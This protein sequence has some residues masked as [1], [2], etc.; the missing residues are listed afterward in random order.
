MYIYLRTP[1]IKT[2]NDVTIMIKDVISM[3]QVINDVIIYLII[4]IIYSVR[5][6]CKIQKLF[7]SL[8]QE[9]YKT[10]E[11]FVSMGFIK[12]ICVGAAAVVSSA[13]LGYF[14]YK[15]Y[16]QSEE[17]YLWVYPKNRQNTVE[18]RTDKLFKF[19]PLTGS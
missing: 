16:F 18:V 5:A 9:D 11:Y 1:V 12:K 19:C 6:P 15:N 2:E 7:L 8:L 13:L 4:L 3:T 17:V 10:L 14:I